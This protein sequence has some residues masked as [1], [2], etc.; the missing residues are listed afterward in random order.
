MTEGRLRA[1]AAFATSVAIF[2]IIILVQVLSSLRV[3]EAR[4]PHTEFDRDVVD[5]S[6]RLAAHQDDVSVA[7]VERMQYAIVVYFPGKRC[8]QLT[9]VLGAL[10]GLQTYCFSHPGNRLVERYS[11]GE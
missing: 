2:A 7:D 4:P 1:V 9:P 6:Y 5:A 10:G 3:C 8:V 11:I